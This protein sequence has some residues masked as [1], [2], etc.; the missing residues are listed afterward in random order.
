[1]LNEISIGP[2]FHILYDHQLYSLPS[3]KVSS[4]CVIIKDKITL[5]FLNNL[6]TTFL[7][8]MPN[9]IYVNLN[10]FAIHLYFMYMI[11]KTCVIFFPLSWQSF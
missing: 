11:K 9:D 8:V 6:Y 1:M 5:E 4:A 7:Y 2:S 3:C 10:Y